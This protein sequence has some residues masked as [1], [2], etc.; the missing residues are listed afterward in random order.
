MRR[1]SPGATLSNSKAPKDEMIFPGTWRE[2]FGGEGPHVSL[3]DL[4]RACVAGCAEEGQ[5]NLRRL[6]PGATLSSSKPP[7]VEMIFLRDIERALREKDHKRL[8]VTHAAFTRE[9]NARPGSVA[10]LTVSYQNKHPDM[11]FPRKARAAVIF[12]FCISLFE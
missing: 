5:N 2:L 4:R 3:R 6:S 11:G 10:T 8:C 9:G 12:F 7:I 1:L